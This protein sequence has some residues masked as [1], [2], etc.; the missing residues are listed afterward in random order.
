ML[1]ALNSKYLL[2]PIK[3]LLLLLLCGNVIIN[4]SEFPYFHAFTF[5]V[6]DKKLVRSVDGLFYLD[7]LS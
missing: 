7:L 3:I 4:S 6:M 5:P 2:V 1:A